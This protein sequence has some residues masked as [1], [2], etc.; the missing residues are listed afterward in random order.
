MTSDLLRIS[1]VFPASSSRSRCVI[2]SSSSTRSKSAGTATWSYLK[3]TKLNILIYHE[4]HV[5][6]SGLSGESLNFQPFRLFI[7]PQRSCSLL[8]IHCSKFWFIPYI[9]IWKERT[10]NI[11]M[12]LESIF[13]DCK[14]HFDHV[15]DPL[16]NFS[17]VK[18]VPKPFKDS[19]EENNNRWLNQQQNLHGLTK[20]AE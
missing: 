14:H 10:G 2:W 19:Y 9:S 15:L 12:Y 1:S 8:L 11:I 5:K 3:Y 7:L 18:N 6:N 17:T 16:V 20:D 13:S 4:W